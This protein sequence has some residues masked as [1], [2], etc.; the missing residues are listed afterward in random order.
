[1]EL[2]E[3]L[4]DGAVSIQDRERRASLI[5]AV[6]QLADAPAPLGAQPLREL[7]ALEEALYPVVQRDKRW[8]FDSLGRVEA[9]QFSRDL[10]VL[11]NFAAKTL[12][13]LIDRRGEWSN[14]RA[15][16][17]D[18]LLHRAIA[19]AIYHLGASIKWCFYRHEPVKPTL[20][21]DLHAMLR[22]A[23]LAGVV[24]TPIVLFEAEGD[25]RTTVLALYL[26]ALLL[27]VLNTG[28]L[29]VRQIEIADGWLAEWTPDY[30]LDEI[31]VPRAHALL[32]DL[33]AMAGLQLVTS[34][35]PKGGFRYLRLEGLKA[36]IDAVKSHLR[37]GQPY[38][39]R[40]T[41]THFAVDQHVALLSAVERLQATILQ[42]SASRIEERLAVADRHAEVHAG[43]AE[44]RA[45]LAGA[46]AGSVGFSFDGQAASASGASAR[47]RV[48]DLSSK[49]IGLTVDRATGERTQVGEILAIRVEGFQ[50]FM[51]GVVVRK[52]TQRVTGETLLGVELL[53]YRPLPVTLL[54]YN[55]AR[56]TEPD[57]AT[58]PI[59]AVY[60]PG[61]DP[62]GKADVLA[63]PGGD[64]GLKNVFRLATR[65][66]NF[67]VRINR[68]LRKGR[69]WIGL[70][71]EV[72]GRK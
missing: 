63:L 50:H 66:T 34:V 17:A 10:H 38:H 11:H 51:M 36:Q 30:T 49:G 28:S 1:M 45:V 2:I 43:F 61:R 23:E 56:D 44:A 27:E 62:E 54:R 19:L 60:L 55:H 52:V 42:A 46:G 59:E 15:D 39:G 3:L 31:Y 6:K 18:A 71:F 33:D 69:D 58:P 22:F 41:A 4:G 47:W 37:S 14:A 65:G 12:K 48:H 64:F 72:I 16:A 67:R 21:P 13:Q 40:G 9:V 25:Q 57:A 24:T 20:W 5:A 8:F 68:V 53:S 35:A 32:V 26:R 29:D 7:F 70:R